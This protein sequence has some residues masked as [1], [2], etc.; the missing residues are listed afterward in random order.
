LLKAFFQAIS[1]HCLAKEVEEALDVKQ[2][3]VRSF[4]V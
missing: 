4:I 1:I 2:E 3:N